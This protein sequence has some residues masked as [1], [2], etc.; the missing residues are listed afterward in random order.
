MLKSKK[1][2]VDVVPKLVSMLTP[3]DAA[4]RAK[5]V[6][7][8]LALLGD[9][10]TNDDLDFKDGGN[11]HTGGGAGALRGTCHGTWL[12]GRGPGKAS[13]AACRPRCRRR[14]VPRR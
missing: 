14:V 12:R 4:D 3:L 7:A 10:G 13:A 5:A 8:A 11:G 1:S 6:R 9:G 2:P